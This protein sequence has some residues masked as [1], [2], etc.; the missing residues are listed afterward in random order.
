MPL[1]TSTMQLCENEINEFKC[2]GQM[3]TMII[4]SDGAR[5]GKKLATSQFNY[6][7]YLPPGYHFLCSGTRARNEIYEEIIFI[8]HHNF[9]HFFFIS[10]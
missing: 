2:N 7:Q 3:K 4:L 9:E 6:S 8:I 10:S 1:N 5:E